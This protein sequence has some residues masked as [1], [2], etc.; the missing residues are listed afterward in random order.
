MKRQNI[1]VGEYYDVRFSYGTVVTC[2]VISKRFF[3]FLIL[4]KWKARW[5]YGFPTYT[6][7]GYKWSWRFVEE[8]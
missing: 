3:G 1:Q 4:C 5:D 2:R 6:E 7:C 8:V